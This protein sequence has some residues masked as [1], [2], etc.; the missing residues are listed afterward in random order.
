MG[1]AAAREPALV[2]LNAGEHGALVEAVMEIHQ[3]LP[4]PFKEHPPDWIQS[5]STSACI[6]QIEA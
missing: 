6:A 1:P 2:A 4:M 3:A 5:C